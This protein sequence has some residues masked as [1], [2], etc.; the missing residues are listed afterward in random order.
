VIAPV[1]CCGGRMGVRDYTISCDTLWHMSISDVL[2]Q[3]DS[4][5]SKLQQ[6][7][8]LL[9]GLEAKNGRAVKPARKKAKR[10]MSPEAREKIAAAQRKRWAKFKR[11]KK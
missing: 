9:A 6:A 8:L 4:E 1:V 2:S 7:R 5:I 10:T 3:I 11:A